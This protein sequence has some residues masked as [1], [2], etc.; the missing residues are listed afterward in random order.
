MRPSRR[1]TGRRPTPW[2]VAA[3]A[4]VPGDASPNRSSTSAGSMRP[5]SGR[6][7]DRAIVGRLRGARRPHRPPPSARASNATSSRPV[8]AGPER[9]GTPRRAEAPSAREPATPGSQPRRR[10]RRGRR[11]G[12]RSATDVAPRL[13]PGRPARSRDP[14]RGRLPRS[15]M[16]R[17][18]VRDDVGRGTV[19]RRGSPPPEASSHG[20]R[21]RMYASQC[22]GGPAADERRTAGAPTGDPRSTGASETSSS[23]VAPTSSIASIASSLPS[24][25]RSGCPRSMAQARCNDS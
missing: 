4:A 9:G 16:G 18:P 14:P 22:A 13:A 11:T 8:V 12:A 24:A 20:A 10:G 19:A 21:A 3:G 7:G 23:A 25:G 17:R 1:S 6:L 2:S 15:G 5:R